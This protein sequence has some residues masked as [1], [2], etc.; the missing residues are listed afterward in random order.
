M[1]R[2]AGIRAPVIGQA[3]ADYSELVQ[4]GEADADTSALILLKRMGGG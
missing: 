3:L 2:E 4:R 1:A